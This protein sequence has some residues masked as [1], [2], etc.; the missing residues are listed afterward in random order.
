MRKA[1]LMAAM[2]GLVWGGGMAGAQQSPR[3]QLRAERAAQLE[4]AAQMERALQ[5]QEA[6]Q[7]RQRSMA[8]EPT[9]FSLDFAGGTVGEY[10][11]SIRAAHPEA[12]IVV[13]PDAALFPMPPIQ[14]RDV[15]TEAAIGV[16]YQESGDAM[17]GMSWLRIRSIKNLGSTEAVFQLQAGHQEGNSNK[18]IVQ[19]L[20][21]VLSQQR[22]KP[23]KIEDVLSA[24]EAATNMTSPPPKIRYHEE[25]MLL[26]FHGTAEQVDALNR[27]I[28][29]LIETAEASE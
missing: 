25:T 28:E 10:V 11:E 22:T 17:R 24:I 29:A 15:T 6:E 2:A 16:V 23:L 4:Q 20:A 5:V 12:N 14:L 27:T 7:N 3:D 13:P 26:L 9:R 18:T 21:G 1:L 19:S 8:P